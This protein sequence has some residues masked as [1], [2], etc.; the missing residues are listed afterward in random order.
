MPV[1]WKLVRIAFQTHIWGGHDID[2]NLP[3]S[4]N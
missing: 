4:S 2:L 3:Q 1:G